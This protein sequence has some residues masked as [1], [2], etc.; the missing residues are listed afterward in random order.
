M[1]KE[2]RTSFF[3]WGKKLFANAEKSTEPTKVHWKQA[4]EDTGVCLCLREQCKQWREKLIF[5]LF[6]SDESLFHLDDVSENKIS[7]MSAMEIINSQVACNGGALYYTV[8]KAYCYFNS[9]DEDNFRRNGHIFHHQCFQYLNSYQ[10]FV[11]S[12]F[13]VK[14]ASRI[15][16]VSRFNAHKLSAPEI[17][18][19]EKMKQSILIYAC[20]TYGEN[21]IF[22]F[23]HRNGPQVEVFIK[24]SGTGLKGVDIPLY[25]DHYDGS[26][27][28]YT[29]RFIN[30]MTEIH[31]WSEQKNSMSY[32]FEDDDF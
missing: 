1:K 3:Q 6:Y 29:L 18:I 15:Y 11:Y 25:E 8:L 4:K 7:T 14:E 9:C 27:W 5:H 13:L 23:Y 12:N 28:F 16:S 22:K 26:R 20:K 32:L 10:L 17:E 30:E 2:K 19:S 31:G 24:Y 21:I